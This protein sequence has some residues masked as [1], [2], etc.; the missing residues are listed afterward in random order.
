M[1]EAKISNNA[2]SSVVGTGGSYVPEVRFI[3]LR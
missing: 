1:M 3:D 2:V